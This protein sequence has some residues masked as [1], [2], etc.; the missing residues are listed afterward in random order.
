M[1]E[2]KVIS[3]KKRSWKEKSNHACLEI[4]RF[5]PNRGISGGKKG[6]EN[7]RKRRLEKV[8]EEDCRLGRSRS[9]PTMSPDLGGTSIDNPLGGKK[10]R[11]RE[12]ANHQCQ[13]Y[14]E[15]KE[16]IQ[17]NPASARMGDRAPH[18]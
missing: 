6:R 3:V 18:C 14:Q 11:G 5:Q 16:G 17:S 1:A 9:L 15:K 10:S 12:S 13:M 7:V 2:E 4:L 8:L